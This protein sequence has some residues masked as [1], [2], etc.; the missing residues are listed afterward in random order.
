MCGD[1]RPQAYGAYQQSAYQYPQQYGYPAYAQQQQG[2]YAY[3]QQY[4]PAVQQAQAPQLPAAGGAN[5]YDFSQ[6]NGKLAGANGDIASAA[7]FTEKPANQ[8]SN[9]GWHPTLERMMGVHKSARNKGPRLA[10]KGQLNG[11]KVCAIFLRVFVCARERTDSGR[12]I[13]CVRHLAQG[14]TVVG[15][16]C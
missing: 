13:W 5:Y 9:L 2:Q 14:E 7:A 6:A 10:L 11:M 15:C 1:A 16:V 12:E 8:Y 4:Q 3:P